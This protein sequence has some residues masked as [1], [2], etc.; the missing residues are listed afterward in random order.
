[1]SCL[2]SLRLREH[3][4]NPRLL[5]RVRWHWFGTRARYLRTEPYL[6]FD[7]EPLAGFGPAALSMLTLKHPM[8]VKDARAA[9]SEAARN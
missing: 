3:R 5:S 7:T 9:I 2:V 1:M 8:A 4:D 6:E